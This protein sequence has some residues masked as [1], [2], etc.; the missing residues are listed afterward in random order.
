MKIAIAYPPLATIKGTPL[1]SQ[2][3]QYQVSPFSYFIY[4]V[5]PAYAA[6]LLK[7]RGYEVYWLDGL[8]EKWNYERW[9]GEVKKIKP[10]LIFIETKT[11]VIKY[12]WEIIKNL[13]ELAVG[14]WPLVVALAGDHVTALPKE[15]MEN[16]PVDFI[17]TGGDYDF[18]LLSIANHLRKGEKLEAG[19]WFRKTQNTKYFIQNTDKFKLDHSL[20]ELPLIDRDLTKWH[21]YAYKN[22]NFYRA[23]GAYTMFGRDCYWGR[24][25]FC[26][27]TTLFPG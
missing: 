23:P 1:L 3:R 26:S 20:D 16:C 10:D 21:L 6:S 24:C 7:E 14:N 27:W 13:K 5:V 17:I 22:S 18:G 12:H 11:P 2:N 8:A 4:P 9:L 19:I 15:T 25:S